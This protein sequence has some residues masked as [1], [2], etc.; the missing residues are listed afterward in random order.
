MLTLN[1]N[2]LKIGNNWILPIN[3]GGI[4]PPTIYQVTT[5][6]THGTVTASPTEGTTGTEV[7]LSN[8]PDTHYHFGSYTLTGATLK[9]TNQ[10]DIG[11][12]DV[13]VVGNFIEDTKYSVTV[14]QSTGGTISA[15]PVQGYTGTE[16]TLSNTPA[17]HY[18]FG[19]Y[20]LTG[21]TLKSANK[22]DIGNSNV[23]VGATWIEDTKYS[24]TCTNDGH[25]TIAASPTSNYS[26]ST[27]TLSNTPNSGYTFDKYTLVSGTG[28]SISGNTLTIGTSNVTVRGDFKTVDPYNPLNLPANTVR[29]RTS[30]GNAPI[31]GS[32]GSA[33]LVAGT[34]DVYDVYKSG[35]SFSNLLTESANVIEVLGA[36]TTGI[37]DM[38][39]MFYYCDSL[40]TVA[41]FDTSSV[42]NM[43]NMFYGC[44]SLTAIPLFNTSSAQIMDYMFANCY[45]VESGALALYQQAS[46][47]YPQPS[48]HAGTFQY[49][50]VSTVSG[51]AEW[52]S[53]WWTAGRMRRPRTGIPAPDRTGW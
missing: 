36:N 47:Q 3:S 5:S 6:G 8:T 43:Y 12:S 24:V 15:S 11:N 38:N 2:V 52:R 16:V 29:V 28:A 32:Y 45:Y 10:F 25:G 42:Y 19:S 21:A 22:F 34:T 27:V 37:T 30:N 1:N 48:S 50:G 44:S 13:S 35:T 31:N 26:G 4:V 53:R 49:C 17:S 7:T 51:I 20:N 40:T 9:N 23:T 33:T 46:T 39:N 41:I 18:S 14:N